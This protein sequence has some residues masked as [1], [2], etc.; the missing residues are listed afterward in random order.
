MPTRDMGGEP[1]PRDRSVASGAVPLRL[2][3]GGT[4]SAYS[5]IS[6]AC[7]RL[8][9][10]SF[11][12]LTE[13]EGPAREGRPAAHDTGRRPRPRRV[14][15]RARARDVDHPGMMVTQVQTA[16]DL[17]VAREKQAEE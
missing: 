6:Q 13:G 10:R 15:D 1:T 3:P 5:R 12:P 4:L 8:A 2:G 17:E 11:G 16:L 9:L 14:V 7:V